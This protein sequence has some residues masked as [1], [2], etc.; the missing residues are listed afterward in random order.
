MQTNCLPLIHLTPPGLF[1]LDFKREFR[2]CCCCLKDRARQAEVTSQVMQRFSLHR[3]Q[4]S[5]IRGNTHIY[6]PLST[7]KLGYV[8]GRRLNTNDVHCGGGSGGGGGGRTFSSGSDGCSAGGG[9]EPTMAANSWT[10]SR[11]GKMVNGNPPSPTPSPAKDFTP[12]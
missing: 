2:R 1:S 12:L 9:P 5:S 11:N 4:T 3:T 6:S 8:A 7:R 10:Q